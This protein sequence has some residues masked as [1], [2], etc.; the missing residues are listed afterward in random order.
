[1]L[2]L[3]EQGLLCAAEFPPLV[4]SVGDSVGLLGDVLFVVRLE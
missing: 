2:G 4:L 1:M 3:A